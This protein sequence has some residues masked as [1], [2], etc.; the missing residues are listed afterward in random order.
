MAKVGRP[1]K[2]SAE[3]L[4]KAWDYI[5][6]YGDLGHVVPTVESLALAVGVH[7][8]TVYEWNKDPQKREFSDA[9][10]KLSAVQHQKLVDK[11][12]EG[13]YNSTIAKLMLTNNHGYAEKTETKHDIS[14]PF[15]ELLSE[16]GTAKKTLG[17]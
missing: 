7:K 11:G 2:Y 4:A 9:L 12:L 10:R 8:D 3:I 13:K 6:N 16:I 14:D 5:E 15:K 1:T 17:D